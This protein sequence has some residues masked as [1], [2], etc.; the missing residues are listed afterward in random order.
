MAFDA[1]HSVLLIARPEY[2]D[3]DWIAGV[4]LDNWRGRI[5][6]FIHDAR[7]EHL[8]KCTTLFLPELVRF[9]PIIDR[10]KAGGVLHIGHKTRPDDVVLVLEEQSDVTVVGSMFVAPELYDPR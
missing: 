6:G 7:L 8:A 3:P 9:G 10:C 2:M 4:R 1:E 5:F